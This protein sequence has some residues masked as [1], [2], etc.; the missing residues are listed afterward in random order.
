MTLR[1]RGA[2]VR[3]E[4][5]ALVRGRD[6]AAEIERC[7]RV[8]VAELTTAPVADAAVPVGL[9]RVRRHSAATAAITV[10]LLV[11]TAPGAGTRIVA[12]EEQVPTVLAVT[13]ALVSGVG[14]ADAAAVEPLVV[15]NPRRRVLP[16]VVRD[17]PGV[18]EVHDGRGLRAAVRAQ[19][20]GGGRLVVLDH[21]HDL[22]LAGRRAV[23]AAAAGIGL[24]VL[25][26]H[27]A[28]DAA[29]VDLEHR[30]LRTSDTG[31]PHPGG[32]AEL[33]P[34]RGGWRWSAHPQLRV[35]LPAPGTS[36]DG[37]HPSAWELQG[38]S[39]GPA[40]DPALVRA[41]AAVAADRSDPDVPRVDV[42]PPDLAAYEALLDRLAAVAR[43][44]DEAL[45]EARTAERRALDHAAAVRRRTL[46]S[47]EVEE[48]A[49]DLLLR[50]VGRARSPPRGRTA[51]AARRRTAAP[52]DDQTEA[53][54]LAPL[55]AA[56][57]ALTRAVDPATR[58]R[59]G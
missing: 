55:R 45:G 43:E 50:R 8:V 19:D 46:A 20:G 5:A 4:E 16:R 35:D 31:V 58:T 44:L 21:P 48:R 25:L 24:R 34:T 14:A 47:V 7:L 10:P 42:G 56:R 57:A 54:D 6:Q 33:W 2:A 1:A 37:P 41:V 29:E 27:H 26:V 49:I 23:H 9:V 18:V 15:V 30:H 53:T 36:G 11:S 12:G 13:A 51:D 59:D 32:G 28:A 22:G 17:A 39:A 3:A 38:R 40:R 52:Q